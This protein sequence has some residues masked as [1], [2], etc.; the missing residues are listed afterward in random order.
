[1]PHV[2]FLMSIEKL[3]LDPLEMSDLSALGN[4]P[5][6]LTRL[7]VKRRPRMTVRGL[8][9]WNG[10]TDLA[11][12]GTHMC[13][14]LSPVRPIVTLQ[15]LRLTVELGISVKLELSPLADLPYLNVLELD[16]GDNAIADLTPMLP[17]RNLRI[18][19][20]RSTLFLR[21]AEFETVSLIEEVDSFQPW[22]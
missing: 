11:I 13:P 7:A 4:R 6:Q 2:G 15:R 21:R 8:E 5:P 1:L 19:A 20:S 16:V 9:R 12:I 3:T 17:H 10:L 22:S 18:I 14:D